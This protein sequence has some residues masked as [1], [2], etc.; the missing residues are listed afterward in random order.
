MD[1]SKMPVIE[2]DEEGYRYSNEPFQLADFVLPSAGR[3][4]DIGTGCGVIPILLAAREPRLEIAAVEIQKPLYD[5]AVHNVARNGLSET[6]EVVFGDFTVLAPTL[7]TFDVIVSNPP[8]RKINSGR[9]NP[10]RVKAV[11]RHELALTLPALVERSFPLL[12]PGGRIVLSYPMHRLEET[13]RLLKLNRMSPRRLRLVH[14]CRGGEAKFFVIEAV[15]GQTDGNIAEESLCVYNPDGSYSR[16]MKSI[17][18]SFNYLGRS[19]R[20][21][22]KR[23]GA[24]AG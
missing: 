22:K 20:I 11:A 15:R 2:Q 23:D 7:G 10:N 14:G 5:A 21:G 4:L 13:R 24:C 3:V 17:Y 18:A 12:K 19:H 6:I 16:E 8:Y 1:V 9:I